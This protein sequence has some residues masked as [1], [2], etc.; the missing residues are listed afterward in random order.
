VCLQP[1]ARG[2]GTAYNPCATNPSRCIHQPFA[3]DVHQSCGWQLRCCLMG[4]GQQLLHAWQA[5]TAPLAVH[6]GPPLGNDLHRRA[7]GPLP[8][9]TPSTALA[10]TLHAS[11][12]VIQKLKIFQMQ[13][14][15]M[16][17]AA[18]RQ[19]FSLT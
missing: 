6:L 8:T 3:K 14:Q 11:T 12:S 18:G 13:P 7:S 5:N 15:H 17:S 19:G 4:S 1:V 16:L 10:L 2:L 9:R